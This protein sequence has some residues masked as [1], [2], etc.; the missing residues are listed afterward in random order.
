[1]QDPGFVRRAFSDIADRYV[2][3]NHVLSM[4]TDILWRRK[5]VRGVQEKEPMLLL[6]VATGSGDV[7]AEVLKQCPGTEIIGADFCQPMLKHARRAGLTNLIVADGLCLPFKDAT[8]DVLTVA[9]GLR[10]MACWKDALTE[11]HRV[12]KPNGSLHVLDFSQPSWQPFRG[13]YLF[14]LHKVLPRIAGLLTGRRQAYEYLS[15]SIDQFPQG[16]VMCT[17]FGETGFQEV[18]A[19]SLSGGIASIYVGTKR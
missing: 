19:E 2:L 15:T 5:F 6:D 10:N 17:L 7:A 13:L 12:L 3:T 1:V 18:T 4:G 9:F 8:F 11:W 16:E 14:Y